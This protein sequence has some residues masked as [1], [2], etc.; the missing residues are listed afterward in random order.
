[1]RLITQSHARVKVNHIIK[2]V[3]FMLHG[4]FTMKKSLFPV[5]IYD[6]TQVTMNKSSCN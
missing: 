1:M 3:K 5:N 2:M 6:M 4:F